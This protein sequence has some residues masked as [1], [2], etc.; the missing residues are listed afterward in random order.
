MR[1]GREYGCERELLGL[2][3]FSAFS[4]SELRLFGRGD[5]WTAFAGKSVLGRGQCLTIVGDGLVEASFGPDA[6]VYIGPGMT[7]GESSL[8]FENSLERAQT[9]VPTTLLTLPN[10]LAL[11]LL[12][13]IPT[14]TTRVLRS[15]ASK[16]RSADM[17]TVPRDIPDVW[18]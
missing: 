4:E 7:V 14:L 12:E 18:P 2:A 15:L 6:W 16:L 13:S 3:G 1:S 5:L 8:V 10:D 17:T 11:R 9:I